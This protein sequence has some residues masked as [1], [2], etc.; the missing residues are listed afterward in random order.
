MVEACDYC[1]IKSGKKVDKSKVFEVFYGELKTAPMI[2]Q[3]PITHACKLVKNIDFGDTHYIFIGEIV[4]S[5]TNEE[6]FTKNI[7]D[8]EKVKPYTWY[9]DNKYYGLHWTTRRPLL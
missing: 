2:K 7:P 9:Y 6:C 5:F 3:A 1:G 4:E 8:I